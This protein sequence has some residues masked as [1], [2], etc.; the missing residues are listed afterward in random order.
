MCDRVD[1]LWESVVKMAEPW[2]WIMLDLLSELKLKARAFSNAEESLHSCRYSQDILGAF[3]KDL[4]DLG[5]CLG[6][7]CK[8]KKG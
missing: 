1:S 3:F 5:L 4:D 2:P 7:L 6:P 8:A